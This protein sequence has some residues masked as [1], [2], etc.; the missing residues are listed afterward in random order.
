MLLMEKIYK[1]LNENR[2]LSNAEEFS[3]DWCNRS[4]SWFAVQKNKGSDF[5]IPAA[6]SLLNYVKV[7]RAMRIL[8][9]KQLGA[10]LDDEIAML[11]SIIDDLDNYLLNAHQIAAVE[12][13]EAMKQIMLLNV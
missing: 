2:L 9:R 1:E 13:T 12:E 6:I 8:K 10:I 4:R 11:T 5:S 7:R 3:T